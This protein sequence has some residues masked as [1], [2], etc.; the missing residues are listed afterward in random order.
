VSSV[1]V[2]N[3]GERPAVLDQPRRQWIRELVLGL[4][5]ALCFGFL[6]LNG[7]KHKKI[8]HTISCLGQSALG[9]IFGNVGILL[10][11]MSFFTD[12]DYTYHN[13][14]IVFIN[15]L[16]LAA[17]PLGIICV[18]GRS[19]ACR[20][21]AEIFLKSLWTA[22]F[23]GGLVTMVIKLFPGFYQQNQVT[24]VLVLPFA[25]VLSFFPDWIKKTGNRNGKRGK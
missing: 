7:G 19:A 3:R 14:N 10:F 5:I 23:L 1:E 13:S 25:F 9:L 16:L 12:H 24:Q 22:V 20:F 17:V 8:F 2:L 18:A 4:F 11:F 6:T 21:K 15:P